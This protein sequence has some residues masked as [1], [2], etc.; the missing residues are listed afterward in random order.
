MATTGAA[1]FVAAKALKYWAIATLGTRWTF[2]VLVPPLSTRIVAGPYR[3]LRHPN[4]VAVAGE[5][6]GVALM[7]R[8][9]L[10]GPVAVAAFVALMLLRIRTEEQALGSRRG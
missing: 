1:V 5:L 7:T 8:A 10:S 4:Y 6:I 3:V 2:R 9:V